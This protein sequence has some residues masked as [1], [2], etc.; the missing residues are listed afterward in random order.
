VTTITAEQRAQ[1]AKL[2]RATHG[3][4]STRPCG[5]VNFLS[6]DDPVSKTERRELERRLV[7]LVTDGCKVERLPDAE[8]REAAKRFGY[9]D[10]CRPPRKH[11]Q[12]SLLTDDSGAA[13][14]GAE[15]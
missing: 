7:E 5:C 6:M 12:A 1:L 15:A 10:I 8:V 13:G 4:V 2:P 14:E 9:C 3:F 11:E